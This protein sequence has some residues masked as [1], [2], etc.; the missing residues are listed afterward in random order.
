MESTIQA[1]Q[2][3]W[4]VDVGAKQVLDVLVLILAEEYI[5]TIKQSP[6]AFSHNGAT[7]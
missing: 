3:S 1:E 7:P 5:Q 2:L 4:T 6:D